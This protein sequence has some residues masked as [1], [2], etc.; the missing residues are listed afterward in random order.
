MLQ[1]FARPN[2][3]RTSPPVSRNNSTSARATPTSCVAMRVRAANSASCASRA[4][5]PTTPR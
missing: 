3:Y 5:V 1:L 2:R 4:C